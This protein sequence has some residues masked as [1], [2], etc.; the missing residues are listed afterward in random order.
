MQK[1]VGKKGEVREELGLLSGESELGL[2]QKSSKAAAGETTPHPARC[3]G[4]ITG[5]TGGL[6]IT[7]RLLL[8]KDSCRSEPSAQEKSQFFTSSAGKD[9]ET[10]QQK[11]KRRGLV[12]LT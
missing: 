9:G 8:L 10:N 12:K 6:A 3:W 5:G 1:P 4:P 2:L 11:K 7:E